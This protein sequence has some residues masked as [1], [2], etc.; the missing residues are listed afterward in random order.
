M[1]A[2]RENDI[3]ANAQIIANTQMTAAA[4][5]L[6][7]HWFP[8]QGHIWQDTPPPTPQFAQKKNGIICGQDAL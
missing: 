7:Y 5:E 1:P 2:T 3:I 8:H 4:E 6:W